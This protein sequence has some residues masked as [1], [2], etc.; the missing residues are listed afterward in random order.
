ML[1]THFTVFLLS[2]L[3][4]LLL[5]SAHPAHQSR[6]NRLAGTTKKSSSSTTSAL[7]LSSQF[8]QAHNGIRAQHGAKD[9]VWSNTLANKAEGW[10]NECA[11]SH[12]H[13][14]LMAEA[15]GENIAAAAG[16]FTPAAAVKTFISDAGAF[17]LHCEEREED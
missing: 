15:Y 13:G 10:A 7:S 9:L 6:A 11:F 5:V 1:F 12:S 3:S 16:T 17:L 14:S 2:A 4:S 8:L